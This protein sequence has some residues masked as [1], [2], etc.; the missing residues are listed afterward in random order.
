[1][2]YSRLT[3]S[4]RQKFFDLVSLHTRIL[5]TAHYSPDDDAIGSTLAL[6]LALS[7]R[8]PG[9][10]IDIAFTGNPVDRFSP[11]VGYESIKFVKDISDITKNYQLVIFLDGSQYSRFTHTPEKLVVQELTTVCIDHHSSPPEKFDLHLQIPGASSTAEL[12]YQLV[13]PQIKL[14]LP[15]CEAI[16]VGI[17]GDTGTFNYIKP[18]QYYVLKI[19]Q[20]LLEFSHIEIQDFKAKYSL[21]SPKTFAVLQ[22]Y[23]RNTKFIDT[24]TSPSFQY[25]FL[26]PEYIK[27]H[28]L[29]DNDTSEASHIYLSHYLRTIAG[30][31]WGFVVTPKTY[32]Y[33]VSFRSLP[34]SVN[35]RRLVEQLNIG[36]GHNRASGGSLTPEKFGGNL[37][38]DLAINYLID[39]VKQHELELN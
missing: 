34:K 22:E 29:T 9:K 15:F 4:F 8:F 32:E 38:L 3:P 6:K 10:K 12:I 26:S 25:S 2:V 33:S 39:W 20:Q 21:I 18:G 36:G 16:L 14:S 7:Q 11:F 17:L 31:S 30:Y 37:S 27:S 28:R 24:T 19:T 23:I 1:M 13:K 5:I 35:V